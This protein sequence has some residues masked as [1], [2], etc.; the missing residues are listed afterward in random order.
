MYYYMYACTVCM[1]VYVCMYGPSL[2]GPATLSSERLCDLFPELC[3]CARPL[4]DVTPPAPG[5]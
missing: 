3:A 4:S 2:P 5:F 1:Y